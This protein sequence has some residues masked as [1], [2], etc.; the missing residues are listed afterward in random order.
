MICV[1]DEE[2]VKY[3]QKLWKQYRKIRNEESKRKTERINRALQRFCNAITSVDVEDEVVD[4]IVALETLFQAYGF[5]LVSYAAQLLGLDVKIYKH[6][7]ETLDQAYD[8]RSKLVHGGRLKEKDKRVIINLLPLVAQI[9]IFWIALSEVKGGVL[10][11][12]QKS[13]FD[14]NLLS[15]M[16]KLLEKW[17]PFYPEI[18]Y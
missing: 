11:L 2:R 6:A 18:K 10:E 14:K 9:I 16:H 3:L 8:V 15:K 13:R 12:I 4:L 17:V 5:K 7:L 1:L